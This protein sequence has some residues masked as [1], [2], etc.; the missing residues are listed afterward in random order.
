[1][2]TAAK[3]A[4]LFDLDGTLLDTLADLGESMNAA[5][6]ELGCATHPLDAYRRFVGDGM[7]NLARRALPAD[8]RDPATVASCVERM[9]GIYG[10]RWDRETRPY[11][12]IEALVA[13]LERRGVPVAVLSNKPDDLT[14]AV[15][16]RYFGARRFAAVAGARADTQRKP[17]PAGALAIARALDCAPS[18]E[19]YVGDTDTDMRTAVSAGMVPIG[20][21]WGFRDADELVASG[22]RFLVGAPAEVLSLL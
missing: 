12:G 6:A 5:L 16:E 11:P 3:R 19:L 9:L 18:T 14:R 15:V 2:S 8:R 17:D 21:L 7:Q 20:A 10:E 1:L 4:V 22:A 13:E